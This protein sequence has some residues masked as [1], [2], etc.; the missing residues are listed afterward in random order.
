MVSE[1]LYQKAIAEGINQDPE[2]RQALRQLMAQRLIEKRVNQPVQS[3]EI[4]TT[5]IKKYYAEHLDRYVRPE[6]LRLSDI[7]VAIPAGSGE[8]DRQHLRE[9]AEKVLAEANSS[10]DR[11][12]FRRLIEKY[13]DKNSHYSL[14][15]TGFFDRHGNPQNIPLKLVQAGFSLEFGRSG[16][17]LVETDAGFHIIKLI[18]RREAY[19]RSLA[20]VSREIEHKIRKQ[21]LIEQRAAFIASL[22]QESKVKI[23]FDVLE[24]IRREM[25]NDRFGHNRLIRKKA[26]R[27]P[28]LPGQ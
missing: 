24:N 5:E 23:N 19:R 1:L 17:E 18:G 14:G 20:D 11:F 22:R 13:S 16:Q 7:F 6:Q 28:G 8:Q 27:P 10:K 12:G 9:K 2:I 26:I 15:D 3:R 21:Q 25:Q 4:S